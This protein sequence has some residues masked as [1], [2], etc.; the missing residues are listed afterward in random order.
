MILCSGTHAVSASL[1]EHPRIA[2]TNHWELHFFNS[3]KAIRN[4]KGIDRGRT[5]RNY[6]KAFLKAVPDLDLSKNSLAV[7]LESS[8][9]YLL[10]SDR[11]PDLIMCATP[12]V[13]MIAIVR[14]PIERASSQYRFLDGECD[15][16]NLASI[17][18]FPL[19]LPYTSLSC[20]RIQTQRRPTHGGLEYMDS[21]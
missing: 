9:R 2:R 10:S 12:W 6:A 20:A 1:W 14:D 16:T 4:E 15:T 3:Q 5:R 7:A 21:R 11:I 8:P 13:K 17:P 18:C 19:P